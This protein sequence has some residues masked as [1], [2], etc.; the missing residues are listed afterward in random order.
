MARIQ[1]GE[2]IAVPL[3]D[4]D[5]AHITAHFNQLAL[6]Q[7]DEQP[8]PEVVKRLSRH[9]LEHVRQL[10]QKKLIQALT[11]NVTESLPALQQQLG[12]ISQFEQLTPVI[13]LDNPDS[14]RFDHFGKVVEGGT[15]TQVFIISY[16]DLRANL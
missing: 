12:P 13:A 4:D 7:G 1:A 9:Y 10:Q 2:E 16:S 3:M 5:Q 14:N 15:H 11:Q 8:N 6:L